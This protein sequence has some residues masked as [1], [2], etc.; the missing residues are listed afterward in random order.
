MLKNFIY[1][2]LSREIEGLGPMT[3]QQ[4]SIFGPVLLPIGLSEIREK[5][6]ISKST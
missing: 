4:P 5:T 1:N 3:S 6:G 2:F